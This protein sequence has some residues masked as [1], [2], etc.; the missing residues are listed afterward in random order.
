MVYTRS[1][2]R[3][4][5]GGTQGYHSTVSSL[6]NY[7]SLYPSTSESISFS[8]G[9]FLVVSS[10][11]TKRGKVKLL[12]PIDFDALKSPLFYFYQPHGWSSGNVIDI[13]YGLYNFLSFQTVIH[14][15]IFKSHPLTISDQENIFCLPWWGFEETKNTV[16]LATLIHSPLYRKTILNSSLGDPAH[17]PL[18][19]CTLYAHTLLHN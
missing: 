15:F 12:L 13:Q 9:S 7:S 4:R 11:S 3:I 2:S 6:K 19:F 8:S 16:I 5:I 1:S 14:T 10:S 17:F 18:I